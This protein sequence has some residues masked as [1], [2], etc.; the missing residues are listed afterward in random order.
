MDFSEIFEYK[1]GKL[2][3]RIEPRVG[4]EAGSE[5]DQ[6]GYR[7]IIYKGKRYKTH[8]LIWEMFNNKKPEGLIDHIDGN[9]RNN[10]IENLRLVTPQDNQRNTKIN[11][12][13]IS[14]II[15]VF[16]SRNDC[17]WYSRIT[18]N[19]NKI[20]LGSFYDKTNRS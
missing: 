9:V 3:W 1:N 10:K 12:K 17:K 16:W 18:V 8:R 15:G 5:T 4:T 13:N 11:S 7:R 2:F 19:G 6:R 14:G 20:H